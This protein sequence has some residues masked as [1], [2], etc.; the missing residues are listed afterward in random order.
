MISLFALH[1]Y[2]ENIGTF[3]CNME[4]SFYLK[5]LLNL[6]IRIFAH[7]YEIIISIM[8]FVCFTANCCKMLL[9]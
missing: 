8:E 6:S 2:Q 4:G 5:F 3:V 1:M 7:R 9:A